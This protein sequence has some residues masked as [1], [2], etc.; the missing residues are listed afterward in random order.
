MDQPYIGMIAMFGFNF[1]PRGWMLCN[2][3]I[4]SIAQNTAL[5]SLLGT[6][7]GGN[8]QTTFALPNLQ[9]RV[10]IGMGQGPGLSSYV[11]GQQAGE[12]NH[13]LISTEMPAHNHFMTASG[14][15]PTQATA[16]SASL[17]SQGRTGGT[18]PAIYA[19]GATTPVQMSSATTIAGGSQPHNNMQ[20]YL[21]I[22][23]SIATQ[24]I[25]PSRN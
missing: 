12:E 2:G 5:F 18:M 25:F 8:G 23:Y 13:T 3:Q 10:P 22:N 17:A 24:G 16:Q 7:Y 15:G 20:P 21:A 1:A 6:T 11:I 4:L 14:D 19:N 9:S